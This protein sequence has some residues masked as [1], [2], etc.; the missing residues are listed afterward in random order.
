M[1]LN[2]I[3]LEDTFI[4]TEINSGGVVY[5][6]VARMKCANEDGSLVLTCDVNT[7]QFPVALNERLTITLATSLELTGGQP[8]SRYY[9]HSIYHRPTRLHECDYAMHGV[10]YGHEVVAGSLDV[11]VYISCGG[12]LC[13]IVGKPQSLRD[14]LYDSELYILFKRAGR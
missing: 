3:I 12:L 14:I 5:L 4:V 11:G 1:S 9:D 10:V 8:G 2:P 13:S 6:K 7:E